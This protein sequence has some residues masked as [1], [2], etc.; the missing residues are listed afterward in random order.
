MAELKSRFEEVI[1][2]TWDQFIKL[3]KNRNATVEDTV[4]CA[5][6]RLCADTDDIS[7]AKTAFDRIEGLQETPID[8]NVPKFYVRYMNAEEVEPSEKQIAAPESAEEKKKKVKIDPATIKLRATLK[9]MRGLPKQVV[10][11]VLNNKRLT[12]EG[13]QAQTIPSV[14]AVIVANLLKNVKKG[15]LRAIDLVFDQIDGKLIRT[16]TLLGGEDVYVDDYLE[17]VAPAGSVKDETGKY[18]FEN[19]A[20]STAWLR[21]FA[22]NQKG[23]DALV[24]G[25]E[26]D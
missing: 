5:L 11:L 20:M 25:L 8:I 19:K 7:A 9:E 16:I 6:V 13:K 3:E 23:L 26:D 21:G 17:T 22:K 1:Q 4:I 18:V 10:S 2:L 15:R 12:E 24:Q 14:K